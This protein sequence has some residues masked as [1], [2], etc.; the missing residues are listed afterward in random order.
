MNTLLEMR[1]IEVDKKTELV[2]AEPQI[3]Q[4]LRSMNGQYS[5]DALD[6]NH[7][8]VFD[9]EVNPIR[10]GQADP[11]V[12]DRQVHLVLKMQMRCCEFVEQARIVGAFEHA[13]AEC[14]LN[15]DG[16]TAHKMTGFIR[17][18]DVSD[19]CV[20]GVLFVPV[21]PKQAI[22]QRVSSG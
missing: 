12:L 22:R 15:L 9:D 21:T 10:G 20:L 19:L 3:R 8:T 16:G 14:G 6:F 17:L 5:L 4:D 2:T 11:L 1:N 7:E 13:G 18:H